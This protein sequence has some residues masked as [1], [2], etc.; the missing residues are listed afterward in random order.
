MMKYFFQISINKSSFQSNQFRSTTLINSDV[1]DLVNLSKLIQFIGLISHTPKDVHKRQEK[2]IVAYNNLKQTSN[3]EVSIKTS[4]NLERLKE[5]HLDKEEPERK[6]D[7]LRSMIHCYTSSGLHIQEPDEKNI[8]L[9][10]YPEACLNATCDSAKLSFCRRSC[11]ASD[12]TIFTVDGVQRGEVYRK[13][14][15]FCNSI[16][17]LNY[18]ETKDSSGDIIRAYYHSDEQQYFSTT[19]ETFYEKKLLGENSKLN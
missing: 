18:Y 7:I 13:Q 8:Y 11:D 5:A 6:L 10:P 15:S 2:L 16:F 17:F 1:M 9:I 19:N 12:V 3:D 14:C 4:C